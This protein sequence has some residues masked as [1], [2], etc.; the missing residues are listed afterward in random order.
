[1]ELAALWLWT[2]WV[3]ELAMAHRPGHQRR[4]CGERPL[5]VGGRKALVTYRET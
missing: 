2:F 1:M 5:Y 3:H 4:C